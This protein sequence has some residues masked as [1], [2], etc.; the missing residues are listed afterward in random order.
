[1]IADQPLRD[2]TQHA[3]TSTLSFGTPAFSV[4]ASYYGEL[5]EGSWDTDN[6]SLHSVTMSARSLVGTSTLSLDSSAAF[7][8]PE[9][10]VP[11]T[12]EQ[13]TTSFS[14]L[15]NAGT[16]GTRRNFS[17]GYGHSFVESPGV[18]TNEVTHQGVRYEGDHFVTTSICM[19]SRASIFTGQYARTHTINDFSQPFSAEQ[20]ARIYPV[21]LRQAGYRTGFIGKWG[22]GNQMPGERFDFFAA[23][24]NRCLSAT[25]RR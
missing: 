11:G 22:V 20:Y 16:E 9:E 24:S 17:Y 3:L 13:R 19:T 6:Y 15:M 18:P 1:M 2:A 4:N 8:L 10:L 14:A 21:L 12:F 23:A 25:G 5:R 7:T